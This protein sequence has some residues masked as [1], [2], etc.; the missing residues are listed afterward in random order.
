MRGWVRFAILT[1]GAW[2]MGLLSVNCW[3]E[4][5]TWTAASGSYRTEAE[6]VE[7]RD[8]GKVVH[9]RLKAGGERDV[10]LEKLSAADQDYV[11]SQSGKTAATNSSAASSST[12]SDPRIADLQRRAGRCQSAEEA[13]RLYRLFR[14]DPQ[15]TD[16]QR[17]AI[18]DEFEKLRSLADKKMM[19]KGGQWVSESEFKSVRAGQLI[20]EARAGIAAAQAGG[21]LPQEVRRGRGRRARQ[22][23]RGLPDGH[24]VHDPHQRPAEDQEVF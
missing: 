19:R 3:A 5:R 14:D 24:A 16:D 12:S 17:R 22:H 23:P 11:R 20:D 8:E 4:F 6:F 1:T 13:L 9:L 10:P 18:L 21:G 15:T 2:L 7:L